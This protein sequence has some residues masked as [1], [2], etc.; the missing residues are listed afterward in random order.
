MKYNITCI[1]WVESIL[2]K[3]IE[4][5][6]YKIT[7]TRDRIVTFEWDLMALARLN[8]WSR[9]GNKVYLELAEW[10]V[11]NFDDL[12]DLIHKI[13]WKYYIGENNPIIVNWVSVKSSLESIPAIQKTAKKAIVTK[14]TWVKDKFL[15]EDDTLPINDILVMIFD[16]K[17]KILLDTTWEAL[18]KRWYRQGQHDAPIKE[19]LAAALVLL[20]GWN[21]R[22]NFYDFFC[23]SWTI[24]IEAALIAKNIAPGLIWRRY[25]FENFSWYPKNFYDEAIEEAKWKMITWK[26]YNIFASDVDEYS[27]ESALINA[28]NA[29]VDDIIKFEIK[30]VESYLWSRNL[31]WTLVSNPPYWLRLNPKDLQTIYKNIS[32]ILKNNPN[33]NWWIIT[34]FLEFDSLINLSNWKKR[35]LYNWNE[36]CYF[37]KKIK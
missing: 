17:A 25:A 8:I 19:S 15:N 36:L 20:S 9:V 37:Y 3:E 5:F 14:I 35:K 28:R 4:R 7:E 23:W 31:E 29:N 13:N 34:S 30:W 21:F 1:P 11:N 32:T 6:G 24:P 18:H 27:I 16:N 10:Y 2:K 12:F 26:T 33:L 22:E